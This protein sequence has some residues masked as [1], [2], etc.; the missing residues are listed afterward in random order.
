MPIGEAEPAS[1]DPNGFDESVDPKGLDEA[2]D[3]G[4]APVGPLPVLVPGFPDSGVL[5]PKVGVSTSVPPDEV[6]GS[7]D[8]PKEEPMDDPNADPPKADVPDE[9]PVAPLTCAPRFAAPGTPA[10]GWPKNPMGG[11]FA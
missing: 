4:L 3:V 6:E 2:P 9:A 7:I 1:V 11:T 10:S 8:D 5:M